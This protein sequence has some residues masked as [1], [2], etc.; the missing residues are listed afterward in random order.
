VNVYLSIT[1]IRWK[2][3]N[4]KIICLYIDCGPN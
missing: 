4:I 2:C 1:L 3:M